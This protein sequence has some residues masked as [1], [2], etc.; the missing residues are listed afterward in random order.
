MIE[1]G[2]ARCSDGIN[3]EILGVSASEFNKLRGLPVKTRTLDHLESHE[4]EA[5]QFA[6]AIARR[7]VE[8]S[9]AHGNRRCCDVCREVGAATRRAML[10]MGEA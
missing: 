9:S 10:A 7:K 3:Q 6:E 8:T 4:L 5:I 2:Y 1:L